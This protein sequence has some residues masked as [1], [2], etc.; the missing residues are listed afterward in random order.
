MKTTIHK[1]TMRRIWYAYALRQVER[2][3]MTRAFW[4]GVVFGAAFIIFIEAVHV[5]SVFRNM[6]AT[7]L[8]GV[9]QYVWSTIMTNIKNGDLVKVVTL[10]LLVSIT[11]SIIKKI[12]PL[13]WVNRQ[14]RTI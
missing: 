2:Q 11:I 13:V 14:S 4:Q 6:L 3:L 8:G 5:A 12:T 10:L 1:S 9:P 7:P